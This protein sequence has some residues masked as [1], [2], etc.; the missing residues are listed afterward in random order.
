MCSRI[1]LLIDK[2]MLDT[3]LSINT[4]VESPPPKECPLRR[5]DVLLR[6]ADD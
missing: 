5:R 2:C 3:G 6:V 4:S 1:V